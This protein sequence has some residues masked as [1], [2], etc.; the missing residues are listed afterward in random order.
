MYYGRLRLLFLVAAYST[1]FRLLCFL[2]RKVAL[3]AYWQ[4]YSNSFLL[5]S[6]NSSLRNAS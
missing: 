4:M 1:N 5:L 2:S 6:V 3:D